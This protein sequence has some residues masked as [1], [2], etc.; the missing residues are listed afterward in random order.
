MKK[1]N[2]ETNTA[3]YVLRIIS[4]EAISHD[5]VGSKYKNINI[6]LEFLGGATKSQ[7]N[8]YIH[9][10]LKSMLANEEYIGRTSIYKDIINTSLH[11][12]SISA[13][14]FKFP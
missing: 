4:C 13:V 7:M 11:R 14:V 10:Y 6:D 2:K 12:Y 3:D 9:D 5:E 8:T 1:R